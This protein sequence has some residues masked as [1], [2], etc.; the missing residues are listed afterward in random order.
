ML[1]ASLGASLVLAREGDRRLH[2]LDTAAAVLWELRSAGL[3]AGELAG[4][5]SQRFGVEP[6]VARQQVEALRSDWIRA[7][8]LG[9]VAGREPSS[10]RR[11]PEWIIPMA[12]KQAVAPEAVPLSVADVCFSVAVEASLLDKA[13]CARLLRP[14]RRHDFGPAEYALRLA[15]T[16]EHWSLY[17]DEGLW[18][19][20]EGRDGAAV[21]LLAALIEVA[22]R[23]RD[24]LMVIHGAGLRLDDG[25]GL[26]LVAAGGSGKSTLAA[27]LNAEGLDLLSDDVVPV[28]REGD[29]L[30]LG[31]AM[32]LKSG[33]WP[34]LAGLR[35]DLAGV[36][37]VRRF[38][39]AVRYLPP[40][41]AKVEHPVRAAALLFPRYLPGS[42]PRFESI[43]A[44]A[45]LQGI[46]EADSVIRNLDQA[47]LDSLTHWVSAIP[48]FRLTYPD[49]A[50]GLALVR[51]ILERLPPAA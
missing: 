2:V 7:G 30:A 35:P 37:V 23:A 16:A 17:L 41:G 22:C 26:L 1:Q 13:L 25:R 21:A 49:L 10:G 19:E 27:A 15:G 50:G 28:T 29:L 18:E 44:V 36:P 45:A 31:A 5:L 48:A 33:S 6:N 40:R 20:G 24:R 4:L 39:Q 51:G 12:G 3:E 43:G 38:G 42:A 47:K 46:V 8:L 14:F 11:E 9:P 34:V 32:C